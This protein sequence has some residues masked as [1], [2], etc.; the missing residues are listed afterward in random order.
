MFKSYEEEV[1]W[2]SSYDLEQP[3]NSRWETV[4]YV[5]QGSRRPRTLVYQ[6]RL[7]KEEMTRLQALA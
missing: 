1:N 3:P 6:L 4:E 2:W 5:P 7:D